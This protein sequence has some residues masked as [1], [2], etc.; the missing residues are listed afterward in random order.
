[1]G[2]PGSAKR[3]LGG[4]RSRADPCLMSITHDPR[5]AS[6]YQAVTSSTFREAIG[7]RESGADPQPIA[8]PG[9]RVLRRVRTQL[10]RLALPL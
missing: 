7:A 2:H 4:R 9:A 8:A 10:V 3:S 6:R 5:P 1:M